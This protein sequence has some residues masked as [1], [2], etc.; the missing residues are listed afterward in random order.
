MNNSHFKII[1]T[2]E[3]RDLPNIVPVG[4]FLLGRLRDL[5]SYDRIILPNDV[6]AYPYYEVLAVGDAVTKFKV[7]DRVMVHPGNTQGINQH[8]PRFIFKEVGVFAVL[9]KEDIDSGVIGV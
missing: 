5:S 7:G 6:Q 1:D 9:P 8:D 2:E 4:E 3:T